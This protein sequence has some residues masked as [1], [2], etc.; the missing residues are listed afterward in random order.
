[1]A[2]FDC[3]SDLGV[4]IRRY[5]VWRNRHLNDPRL[6]RIIRRANTASVA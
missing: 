5:I 2:G 1:V 3:L 6:C 4:L